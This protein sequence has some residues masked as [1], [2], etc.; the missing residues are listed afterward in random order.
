MSTKPQA[1]SIP[2]GAA[3]AAILA[4]AIGVFVMGAL[5]TLNEITGA[6]RPILVWYRPAGPLTGK[7][8]WAVLI[9]LV[10]WVILHNAWKGREQNFGKLFTVSLILIVLGWLFMFPLFFE[11]FS[12]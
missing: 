10:A 11:M 2:N 4:A 3:A 5:T 1:Q 6:L 8:G 12:H 7:T 9:W